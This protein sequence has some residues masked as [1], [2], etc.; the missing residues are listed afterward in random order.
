[1]IEHTVRVKE[2][3]A[4]MLIDIQDGNN[5]VLIML[6]TGYI[7]TTNWLPQV[8]NWSNILFFPC[9]MKILF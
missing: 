8:S 4:E 1:V 3:N 9:V 5:K 6:Y 7:Y 2:G